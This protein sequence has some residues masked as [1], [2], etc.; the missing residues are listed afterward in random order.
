MV[1]CW[2][3][4]INRVFKLIPARKTVSTICIRATSSVGVSTIPSRDKSLLR[5]V[6]PFIYNFCQNTVK[7]HWKSLFRLYKSQYVEKR[8]QKIPTEVAKM[9]KKKMVDEMIIGVIKEALLRRVEPT[10]QVVNECFIINFQCNLT[11]FWLEHNSLVCKF[12][13][14]F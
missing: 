1:I 14:K 7:L 3:W 12:W 6:E 10:A 2:M 11:V 5:M 9:K 4:I 8:K 13:H